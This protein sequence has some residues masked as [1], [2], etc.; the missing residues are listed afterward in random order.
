MKLSLNLNLNLNPRWRKRLQIVGFVAFYGFCLMLFAYL[1]FPYDRL[2]DRIITEFNAAQ[3]GPDRMELELDS[4]SSYWL[5][6]VEAEGIRLISQPPPKVGAAPGAEVKPSVMSIESAHARLGLWGLLFGSLHL[7]FGAEAFGGSLSGATSESEGTRRLEVDI[8][9]VAL[10]QAPLL[11]DVVG[12]PV[13]GTMN[14]E[15]ELVLPEGLL[16]KA[17]GMVKL[18]IEELTVGDGK[19]KI[20]DTIALPPIDAGALSF[21]GKATEGQLD[22]LTFTANGPDLELVSE[23]SVRLRDPIRG[24]LLNLSARFRFTD[25]YTGKNEMTRGLFGAPGSSA[26]GLFDLDP[27]NKRAK[28]P[29]GFYGW[30]AS[31]SLGTPY[32]TPSP[33]SGGRT[34]PKK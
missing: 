31:G 20:R 24:S 32:F 27:K 2:K 14:G 21:E 5:S 22:V 25:R 16:A 17:D 15:M 11:A 23:G 6:G 33:A 12:L 34:A 9:D 10:A 18:S 13:A 28:R 3:T 26:P 30:R 7:S 1:T 4:L 19:A 29:D 8:D